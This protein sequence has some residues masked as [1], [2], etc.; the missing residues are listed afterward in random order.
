MDRKKWLAVSF[1]VSIIS[2]SAILILTV[3]ENTFVYLRRI[4]PIYLLIAI[5]LNIFSWFVWGL[6][7]KILAESLGSKLH[8]LKSTKI[9]VANLLVA[10]I[11]PSMAGGEPIRIYLLRKNGMK[12][13]DA[14]AVVLGE[15][16]LD[17]LFFGMAAP[18]ALFL[19][20]DI[21]RDQIYVS[22]LFALAGVLLCCLLGMMIYALFRHDNLKRWL[23]ALFRWILPKFTRKNVD[24]IVTRIN[25]EIDNFNRSLWRLLREGKVALTLAIICTIAFWLLGFAIPSLILMGLG[26]DPVWLYSIMAQIILA[27]IMM[28]PITPGSSGLAELGLVSLYATFVH[29]PLLGILVVIWRT[30][31]YYSNIIAGSIISLKML[32][33]EKLI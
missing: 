24:N 2:M 19:F 18:I 30:V 16:V 5:G 31:T 27:L 3:D 21:V 23:S 17:G 12:F 20:K 29:I 1:T 8:I 15:R 7:I 13:G 22:M 4:Q 11:T 33:D 28:I 32:Q 6:R 26:A 10:A 25:T 9:V 14:S